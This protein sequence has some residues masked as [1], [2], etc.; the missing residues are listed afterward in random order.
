MQIVRAVLAVA[1]VSAVLATAPSAVACG[2]ERWPEKTL[3][4]RRASLVNFTPKPTSIDTLRRKRVRRDPEGFR[5]APV[6]TTV[7]RVRARLIGVRAEDDGDVHLVISTLTN[8]R[9]TMIVE[10]PSAD[11]IAR[12]SRTARRKMRAA[13][14]SFERVSGPAPDTF[15]ALHG[16]A[17]IDGVGF[18]DLIHGQTGIAPNGIELHPVTR[19]RASSC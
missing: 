18:F 4:D 17:T 5:N 16:T 19:F 3:Q 8:H 11:C 7:Y 9:R 6:E 2:I 1:S 12:A 15:E 13:R 14:R 10:M